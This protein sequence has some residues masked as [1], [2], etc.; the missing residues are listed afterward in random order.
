MKELAE[1]LLEFSKPEANY[2]SNDSKSSKPS[3]DGVD[4]CELHFIRC[5]KPNEDK[6]KNLF[7]HAMC[8]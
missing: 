7:I 3:L 4:P 6:E 8:L 2:S 5:I 1:P